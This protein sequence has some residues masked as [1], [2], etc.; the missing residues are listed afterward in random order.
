MSGGQRQ[1]VAIARAPS[2]RRAFF[3][4][5]ERTAALGVASPAPFFA[6]RA[7]LPTRAAVVMVSLRLLS[8]MEIADR[9]VVMRNGGRRGD[10]REHRAG[11]TD[12][13]IVGAEQRMYGRHFVTNL[14]DQGSFEWSTDGVRVHSRTRLLRC[15]SRERTKAVPM[16]YGVGA[17]GGRLSA[18]AGGDSLESGSDDSRPNVVRQERSGWQHR[19]LLL[20]RARLC[21]RPPGRARAWAS[22]ASTTTVSTSRRRGRHALLDRVT[23][24]GRT[25]RSG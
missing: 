5:D 9:V 12:L 24:P 3:L 25:G 22:E 7:A 2:G 18:R 21:G 11:S 17:A 19:P 10:H 6:S 23:S 14:I 15:D 13:V 20:R 16:R 4:I 1:S 8:L